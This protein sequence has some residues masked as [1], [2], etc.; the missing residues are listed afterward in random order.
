MFHGFEIRVG[1]EFFGF[2]RVHLASLS[3]F[4]AGLVLYLGLLNLE[5]FYDGRV[6]VPVVAVHISVQHLTL[7]VFACVCCSTQSNKTV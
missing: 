1:K 5:A 6:S 3:S 4:P 2:F 7:C